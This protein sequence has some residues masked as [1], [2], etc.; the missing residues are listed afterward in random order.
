MDAHYPGSIRKL[1]RYFYLKINKKKKR[2]K[3]LGLGEIKSIIF[4][5]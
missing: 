2:E 1:N 3:K 4:F 5:Y